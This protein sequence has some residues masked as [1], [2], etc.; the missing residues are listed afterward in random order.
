VKSPK[1]L[2]WFFL[3]VAG[4]IVGAIAVEAYREYKDKKKPVNKEIIK[5]ESL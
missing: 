4:A 3:T 2:N 5:I 1:A